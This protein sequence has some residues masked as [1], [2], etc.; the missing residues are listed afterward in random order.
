MTT[1][2]SH[3]SIAH[4]YGYNED[5][6]E[7]TQAPDYGLPA[8]GP[9]MAS[10]ATQD[11]PR[12]WT[13]MSSTKQST[14]SLGYEPDSALRYGNPNFGYLNSP[15]VTSIG[16][17]NTFHPMNSLSKGLPQHGNR[18]LPYP[19]KASAEAG[20]SYQKPGESASYSLPSGPSQKSG[21]S[22]NPQTLTDGRSQGSISSKSPSLYSAPISSA[23]SSPPLDYSHAST[24]GYQ[25]TAST[26]PLQPKVSAASTSERAPYQTAD[27]Y[28]NSGSVA[29]SNARFDLPFYPT[30]KCY[31]HYSDPKSKS[32]AEN[33]S[34]GAEL[35]NGKRY[36]NI[37]EKPVNYN[38]NVPLPTERPPMIPS[39]PKPIL[40]T[41]VAAHR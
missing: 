39:T 4:S 6:F 11:A 15:A 41:P 40:P 9:A 3:P 18:I 20:N 32:H 27:A 30:Q 29:M 38:P 2:H 5:P 33:S 26:S 21:V 35:I 37:R 16:S 23:S 12:G 19:A 14:G 36:Q 7:Y 34:E 13:S 31:P 24:F 22:Y 25:M 8:Q 1:R 17:D 28:R 10:Y